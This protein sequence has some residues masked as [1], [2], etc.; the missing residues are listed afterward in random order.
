VDKN[1]KLSDPV[2]LSLPVGVWVSR[3]SLRV[4]HDGAPTP[5]RLKD[6][7]QSGGRAGKP[8]RL[9]DD[10]N[11]CTTP[12]EPMTMGLTGRFVPMF[13]KPQCPAAL[14]QIMVPAPVPCEA[15][16]ARSHKPM[17][18]HRSQGIRTDDKEYLAME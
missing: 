16:D 13:P 18:P 7:H 12:Q 5:Q 14:V 10:E 8:L 11:V 3:L 4:P 9:G 17:R 2:G 15:S 1:L 6:G